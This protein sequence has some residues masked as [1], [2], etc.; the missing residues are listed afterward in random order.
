MNQKAKKTFMLELE[1]GDQVSVKNT[2]MENTDLF[3]IDE[4][5]IDKIRVSK[6]SLNKKENES[7][8]HYVFYEYDGEYI[9]LKIILNDVIGYHNK[10]KNT[11]AKKIKLRLRV[12]WKTSFM[13]FLRV[14]ENN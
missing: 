5:D 9:T 14:L 8:K 6:N 1:N 4:I 10:F 12:I 7:Y 11:G 13:I 2:Y 3:E